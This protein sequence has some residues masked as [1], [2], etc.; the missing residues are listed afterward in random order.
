MRR[1]TQGWLRVL[2]GLGT[3][4]GILVRPEVVL[5]VIH[6]EHSHSFPGSQ[7]TPIECSL[8]ISATAATPNE[9]LALSP[10]AFDNDHCGGLNP[11]GCALGAWVSDEVQLAFTATRG[12]LGHLD[13]YGQFHVSTQWPT[14]FRCG[15]PG[16]A[17]ITVTAADVA[18][19]PPWSGY[20]A[21]DPR[22]YSVPTTN[23]ADVTRTVT[24]QIEAHEHDWYPMDDLGT[25]WV[26]TP[27]MVE[28][29][30]RVSVSVQLPEDWDY[31]SA[32][33]CTLG[34]MATNATQ[35]VAWEASAGAFGYYDV[36]GQWTPTT[37]PLLITH[38]EAPAT[39]GDY[40][41]T[42]RIDDV[43]S[44]H[45]PELGWITSWNDQPTE[46]SAVVSVLEGPGG[47]PGNGPGARQWEA[48][49]NLGGASLNPPGAAG[50]YEVIPL[51]LVFPAV[52]DTDRWYDPNG[53]E[54]GGEV[55]N[56]VQPVA[57][58]DDGAGGVFGYLT[59]PDLSS[60]VP[61][62]DPALV[63]HYMTPHFE[64]PITLSVTLD[65]HWQYFWDPATGGVLRRLRRC[66]GSAVCD[67]VGVRGGPRS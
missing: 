64:G 5:A 40:T 6:H 29:G 50:V 1:N 26:D 7:E 36:V 18:Q 16:T 55:V 52:M 3:L 47:G 56:P 49:N 22:I 8:D 51:N 4:L 11:Y 19:T 24:V 32:P 41:L 10:Y 12:D 54:P 63:T 13:A 27:G 39:P 62:S 17:S 58:S 65:D 21:N 46:G 23:D 43:T 59:G 57:W 30:G 66:P 25:P 67:G 15:P 44:V 9:I 48:V 38:W 35:A 2:F 53:V 20:G 61:A 45:D 60:F 42:V 28:A 34:T 37:D 14:H 31:C 33:S